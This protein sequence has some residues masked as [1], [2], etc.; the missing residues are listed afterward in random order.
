M[1]STLLSSRIAGHYLM[2][3]ELKGSS[4]LSILADLCCDVIP[5]QDFMK[6]HENVI[7]QFGGDKPPLPLCARATISIPPPP[8]FGNLTA[9]CC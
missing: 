9:Q 3:L 7:A 5:G 8:L 1:A 2:M 6:H 4:Y